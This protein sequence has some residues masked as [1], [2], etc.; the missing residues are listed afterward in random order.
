L[1][2]QRLSNVVVPMETIAEIIRVK[3]AGSAAMG[4]ER[5]A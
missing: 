4:E 1:N 3:R 2:I 5:M